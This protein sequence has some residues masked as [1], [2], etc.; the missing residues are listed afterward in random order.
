[1]QEQ[2]VPGLRRRRRP[3]RLALHPQPSTDKGANTGEAGGTAPSA[4]A[5]AAAIPL[6]LVLLLE[7]GLF[8][9]RS[10]RRR[11]EEL[12]RVLKSEQNPRDDCQNAPCS[13]Q[14]H[15]QQREE[16][17]DHAG[18]YPVLLEPLAVDGTAQSEPHLLK[19]HGIRRVWLDYRSA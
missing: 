4:E 7:L 1:M 15:E 18:A 16:E 3:H 11:V 19:V 9:G 5:D 12:K 8:V 10:R 2:V 6:P 14:E 17:D 13:D